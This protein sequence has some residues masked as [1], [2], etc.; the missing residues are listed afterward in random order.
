MSNNKQSRIYQCVRILSDSV[1]QDIL[2]TIIYAYEKVVRKNDALKEHIE[3]LVLHLRDKN[4]IISNLEE[5]IIS[6][7]KNNT[8][9][10]TYILLRDYAINKNIPIITAKQIRVDELLKEENKTLKETNKNLLEISEQYKDKIDY[11]EESLSFSNLNKILELKNKHKADL[12]KALKEASNLKRENEKLKQ[13]KDYYYL[14]HFNSNIDVSKLKSENINLKYENE[15]L[16][17][18]INDVREII[19]DNFSNPTSD[20]FNLILLNLY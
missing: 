20:V 3:K 16:S 7:N 8:I 10:D 17:K 11:L 4:K 14:L 5:E 13:E 9:E 6:L 2:D 15:R 18:N 12:D 1:R 19:K